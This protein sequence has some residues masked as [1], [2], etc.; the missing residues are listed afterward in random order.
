[1]K[2]RFHALREAAKKIYLKTLPSPFSYCALC[3]C[4]LVWFLKLPDFVD[5]DV[6][7]ELVWFGGGRRRFSVKRGTVDHIL[8]LAKGGS[9][10]I[11]NLAG[12]CFDCHRDKDAEVAGIRFCRKCYEPLDENDFRRIHTEC[13]KNEAFLTYRLGNK[14][15]KELLESVRRS[16]IYGRDMYLK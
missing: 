7:K 13:Q 2:N 3:G 9:N 14:F 5:F 10:Q 15:P 8:P 16:K 1:M 12:L 11:T 4:R 6:E